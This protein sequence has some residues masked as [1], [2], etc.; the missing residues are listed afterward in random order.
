MDLPNH[1][2]QDPNVQRVEVKVADDKYLTL[3][4]R[5]HEEHEQE[6]DVTL[7]QKADG[8]DLDML[9]YVQIK[10]DDGDVF[11]VV[12]KKTNEWIVAES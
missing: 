7:Y 9:A 6:I 8:E 3:H 5:P 10:A 11:V 4:V 12:D 1:Q 2:P